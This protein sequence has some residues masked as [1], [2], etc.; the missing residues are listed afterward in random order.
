MH[1]DCWL[2][3]NLEDFQPVHLVLAC[4]S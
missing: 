2:L 4:Q 3:K 1:P